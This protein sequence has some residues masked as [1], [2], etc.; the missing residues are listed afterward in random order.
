MASFALSAAVGLTACGNTEKPDGEEDT[1][2]IVLVEGKTFICTS[3]DIE[4]TEDCKYSESTIEY[5][6]SPDN[7]FRAV[8][9]NSKLVFEE[10]N[11][12]TF[13]YGEWGAITNNEEST[14][15]NYE[16]NEE[17]VNL[18][19]FDSTRPAKLVQDGEQFHFSLY[20]EHGYY[21]LA[22]YYLE[23]E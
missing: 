2:E 7:P 17:T 5:L 23:S 18:S 16:Q 8:Y 6:T 3:I 13:Y 10:N 12:F 11:E 21:I 20:N 15:G 14:G 4:I 22:E 1:T 19:F 9:L